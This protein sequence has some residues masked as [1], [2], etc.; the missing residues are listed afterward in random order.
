[1]EWGAN[2]VE[3]QSAKECF[4]NKFVEIKEMNQIFRGLFPHVNLLCVL[5]NKGEQPGAMDEFQAY[6]K[7]IN[8]KV[9]RRNILT[10]IDKEINKGNLSSVKAICNQ[11]FTPNL[12]SLNTA[13]KTNNL[14]AV[15]YFMDNWHEKFKKEVK[16]KQPNSMGE[17]FEMIFFIQHKRALID[18]EKLIQEKEMEEFLS[19]SP[20]ETPPSDTENHKEVKNRGKRKAEEIKKIN[21]AFRKIFP[22]VQNAWVAEHGDKRRKAKNEFKAYKEYLNNKSNEKTIQE[23]IGNEIKKGDLKHVK[24]ICN[25]GFTPDLFTLNVAVHAKDLK[26]VAYFMD[27]WGEKFEKELKKKEA[28]S[29]SD[30]FSGVIN[31]QHRRTLT[32]AKKLIQEN[33][34]SLPSSSDTPPSTSVKP[35]NQ[36]KGIFRNFFSKRK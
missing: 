24:A 25:L 7:Y 13:V 36:K 31:G 20:F 33:L 6:S 15:K 21:Q 10:V 28:K 14:E 32:K 1:M 19:S 16:K 11:G 2:L 17:H 22:E 27:N 35:K 5:E 9:N 8:N 29:D 26:I 3:N 12:F 18:A 4:K 34:D 23:A 30:E